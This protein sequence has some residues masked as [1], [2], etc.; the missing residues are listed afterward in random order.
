MTANNK[1]PF[2]ISFDSIGSDQIGYISVAEFPAKIPFAIKRVFWSYF[3]PQMITRGRHAHH[4]L[5]Q[6]LVA[7]SGKIIVTNESPSGETTTHILE[8]PNEGLYIPA[9]FW[10]II[11]FSHNAVMMSLASMEYNEDD[12]IRDYEKYKNMNT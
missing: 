8:N 7:V 12:Y 11:Q 5:E 9:M 3:T 4:K 10:H 2:L 6:I 1:K